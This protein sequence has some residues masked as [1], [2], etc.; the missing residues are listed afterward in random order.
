[1]RLEVAELRHPSDRRIVTPVRRTHSRAVSRPEDHARTSRHRVR[2]LTG[3]AGKADARKVSWRTTGASV[4]GGPGDSTSG[5]VGFRGDN[6]CGWKWRSFAELR[7]GSALGG[8]PHGAKIRVLYRG[9]KMTLVLR[10]IGLG[11]GDVGGWPRSVDVWWKAAK[12]LHI[13]GLAVI[14]YRRIK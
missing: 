4:Y 5:C 7:M 12:R 9:R 8:L 10:D 6:L 3:L 13:H 1:M 11:G 14:R 2:G